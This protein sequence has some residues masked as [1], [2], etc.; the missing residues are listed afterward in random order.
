LGYDWGP[1]KPQN[2]VM[3]AARGGSALLRYGV[4]VLAVGVALALKLLLDPLIAQDV[5]FLLVFGAIMVS[6]WYG[7]LGPGLLATAAAGLATDYFFLPPQGSFPVW[8]LETVPLVVF[9]LEGALVCLLAE[10]LRAARS[11]AESS[12]LEAERHQERL[13]RSEEHFRSLVESTRNHA[14]FMLDPEGRVASWNAGAE[15]LSGY[16][17]EEIMGEHYSIF[18]TAEDTRS[19]KPDRHLQAAAREGRSQEEHW[20]ERKDGSRFLASTVTTALYEEGG[21]PRGF[22]EVMQ[23]ITEMK[24]AERLLEE[25]G[26][27]L[28]TLVEHVPAITYTGGVD[29]DHALDYVSP[30]IENVLG[31]SPREVTTDPEHWTKTLHP[32]DR[33]WVLAEEKRTGQTGDPFALEYRMFARNGRVVWLRDEAMLV[34]DEEG[35]P[36]HWQGFILDVT[37][38]KKAEEK[39]RESEELYRNVVEQ[40][41]ENIFL[42]DPFTRRILQANASFH[43]SLGYEDKEL[44]RLTLYDIVAHDRESID[45][46]I[47]RVL[48]EGRLSIGERSYRRKD[49]TLIDVEVSVGA[50]A[51]GGRPALCVVAHDVTQRKE[52]EEAL[53]RSLNALLALYETGQILSSSLERE[54]IG[55]RLLEVVRRVSNLTAAVISTPDEKGELSIW[56][57]SGLDGS[58]HRTRFSPEA[59][60][61]RRDV[62]ERREHRLIR[63]RS[64]EDTPGESLVSLYL[65]LLVRDRLVGVLEAHGPEALAEEGAET[66]Y[67]LANQAAGALENARLYAELAERESQLQRLVGKLIMAQ[68]E[69]RRR[70]AHDVHDGL[71]QTAAAA[72]QHLQAF[73]RHNP[74]GS[75]DGRAELD[76]TLELVREVVGEAR[77]VIYDARPTVLDDYG[78]AA[79][80]RLQVET[81]RSEGLEVHFAEG[82]GDERLLPEVETTLFRVAQE[83]LTNVRKHARASVVHVVLDRP[84][85]GVRL[86]VTDDG[87]GFI[88]EES[89]RSSGP[90]ER[91]GLSGMRERLSLLGGRF[92]LTSEPGAGTTLKAEVELPAPREDSDHAG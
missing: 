26:N 37:E 2:R 79:A 6:A 67:S 73:A 25:T 13:R 71:A 8:S 49:G 58:W 55:S 45:R 21:I 72:H 22:S 23:D 60:A 57:S 36:L 61:A 46:N 7:G 27:S 43:H 84:G 54:E 87:R 56:R 65:P 35:N 29:G 20:L 66:L 92:E 62:L 30:Q 82:L 11:R 24:E 39:L 33:R 31:Y 50:I 80:V 64:P 1:T 89:P 48:E 63:L 3:S 86:R 90:G 88:P 76:E 78:L 70:V 10:A 51:H 77:R 15:R 53:K 40:A 41:V 16:R 42:V 75:A 83:A 85:T 91:V 12:K 18:F 81:L 47:Q 44:R 32:H 4:A 14:I 19:G 17:S 69:E 34:R 28:R 74:P 9:F 5:P 59:L 68:E 38:R 52:A